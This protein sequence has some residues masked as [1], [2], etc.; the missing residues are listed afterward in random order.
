[1]QTKLTFPHNIDELRELIKASIVV[2]QGSPVRNN[3]KLNESMAKALGFCNYDHLSAHLKGD[4]ELQDGNL[5]MPLQDLYITIYEEFGKSP[6]TITTAGYCE[7]RQSESYWVVFESTEGDRHSREIAW[8]G[9]GSKEISEEEHPADTSCPL[10]FF[11]LVPNVKSPK[12]RERV[13]WFWLV[14]EKTESEQESAWEAYNSGIDNYRSIEQVKANPYIP[15]TF[16]HTSWEKGWL[17]A[18]D[19]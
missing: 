7:R 11:E 4:P 17:H 14:A 18:K 16:E 1:M 10:Y 3:N 12:W 15:G 2:Y 13:K 5:L 19:I 9:G 8:L 6:L